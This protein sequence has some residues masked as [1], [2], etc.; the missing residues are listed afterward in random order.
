MKLKIYFKRT[1]LPFNCMSVLVCLCVKSV[2]IIYVITLDG[3]KF[4]CIKAATNQQHK[5]RIHEANKFA[6]QQTI[7]LLNAFRNSYKYTFGAGFCFKGF[8]LLLFSSRIAKWNRT[9][10]YSSSSTSS[11]SIHMKCCE[12]CYINYTQ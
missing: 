11:I 9:T 10:N 2:N 4:N 12:I 6:K 8:M 1:H 3:R 7:S 5:H